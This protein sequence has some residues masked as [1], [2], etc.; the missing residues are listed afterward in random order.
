MVYFDPF[1]IE[2]HHIKLKQ[3]GANQKM[4]RITRLTALLLALALL[5]G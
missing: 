5:G 3:E 4:K 2:I 1:R